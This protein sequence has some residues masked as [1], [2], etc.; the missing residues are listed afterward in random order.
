MNE[1]NRWPAAAWLEACAVVLV[2]VATTGLVPP[3]ENEPNYLAKARHFWDPQWAA[4]DVYLDSADAHWLFCMATG[5]LTQLVDLATVAQILRLVI[6]SAMALGWIA[7]GRAMGLRRG[8]TLLAAALFVATNQAANVSGE[9]V[10]GGCEAKGFAYAALLAAIAA[11]IGGR[12]AVVVLALGFAMAWHPLV[13]G[14][15]ALLLLCAQVLC[16]LP[17][18]Q[19]PVSLTLAC[20]VV[21]ALLAALGVWPAAAMNRG[22]SSDVVRE[23]HRIY[24]FAR[25]PHHL[26]PEAFGPGNWA[27]F[28]ALVGVWVAQAALLRR[29]PAWRLLQGIAAAAL[30]AA[31]VG[32]LIS[33]GTQAHPDWKAALLRYY[34][35]RAADFF[36]PLGVGVGGAALALGCGVRRG[37]PL[38]LLAALLA[39]G[40]HFGV[41]IHGQLTRKAPP[42][43]EARYPEP[44]RAACIWARE[45]TPATAR[46]LTPRSSQTF[47]WYAS[48]AEVAN[49]KETPQDA[50]SIVDWWQRLQALY[51]APPGM[52]TKTPG[53]R[54]SLTERTPDELRKL[55]VHYRATH[56]LTSAEPRLNLPCAYRNERY[57]VYLFE[58]RE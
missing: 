35:F 41:S 52:I 7:L 8:G 24:V 38:V 36:V 54:A 53:W 49:W 25:L 22:A 37:V 10:I 15:A 31:L 4:G 23:A 30:F 17:Q 48:R 18:R 50:R 1:T 20:L 14:W 32:T 47:K 42:G 40:V 44:W 11:W 39:V 21:A 29:D 26:L 16:P 46:F 51:G 57:A 12:L 13:G 55:A 9:W 28:A 34:W 43:E 5:W 27:R 19:E 6:W 58:P 2:F 56:L 3:E 33:F 45:H